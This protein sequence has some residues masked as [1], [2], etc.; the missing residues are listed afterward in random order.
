MAENFN[1]SLRQLARSEFKAYITSARSVIKLYGA[2]LRQSWTCYDGIRVY[3]RMRVETILLL[4]T[5]VAYSLGLG[6]AVGICTM[7]SGAWSQA[8]TE[9]QNMRRH[10]TEVFTES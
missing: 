8:S 5:E 10:E 6:S 4:T 2:S 9:A 7:H 3:F 1:L